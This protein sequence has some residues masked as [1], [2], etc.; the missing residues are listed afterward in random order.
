[1]QEER[2]AL[3][4]TRTRHCDDPPVADQKQSVGNRTVCLKI[5]SSA[6]AL[7]LPCFLAMTTRFKFFDTSKQNIGQHINKILAER[8]L[9]VDSVVKNYLTTAPDGKKYN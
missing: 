2:S 1:M 5:A 4:I 6:T 3:K 8:E 7:Y 9:Q